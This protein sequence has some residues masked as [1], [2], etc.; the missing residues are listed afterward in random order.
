VQWESLK[1][2]ESKIVEPELVDEDRQ[3]RFWVRMI[4]ADRTGS[5]SMKRSTSS[6]FY[7]LRGYRT[8]VRSKCT[9]PGN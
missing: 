1:V 6:T 8:R 5:Q 9:R 2:N 3:A 7:N 4:N